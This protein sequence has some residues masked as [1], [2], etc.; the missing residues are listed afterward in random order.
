M[1]QTALDNLSDGIAATVNGGPAATINKNNLRLVA[2]N[3][4]RQLAAYVTVACKGSMPNLILSGF[5]TQKQVRTPVGPPATAA[6]P[7]GK[8]RLAARSARRQ[9]QSGFGRSGSQL[10]AD[11]GHGGSDAHH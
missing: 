11:P 2:A 10:P 7:G 6:G 5:P 8:P 3:L 9:G 4:M 1:I